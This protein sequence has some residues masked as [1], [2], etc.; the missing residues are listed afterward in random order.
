MGQDIHHIFERCRKRYPGVE[1]PLADYA[2]RLQ[3]VTREASGIHEEDLF[4]AIACARG[5]HVAWDRFA[6][7]CL[8]SLKHFALQA[9][10]NPDQAEDLA[11]EVVSSLM[12]DSRKLTGY[13]GR[14][15]L[16]AW[17]RVAVARAAIDRFRQGRKQVSLEEIA[18]DGRA[19]D[20]RIGLTVP[21]DAGQRLDE[22][23]GVI[24]S[25]L[26]AA[27]IRGLPARDRLLLGLYYVENVPLHRIA[28][29]FGVHESTASRW[30]EGLRQGLRRRVE[31]E[32]RVR[33]GLSP[34]EVDALWEIAAQDPGGL[35]I[36]EA[37]SSPGAVCASDAGP[38]GDPRG[39]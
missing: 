28:A 7:E 9:C 34:R 27:E 12:A 1:L 10:R 21:A 33:H 13:D 23:W 32:F 2:T 5:N 37:L 3:E 31:R 16:M 25:E 14:G 20:P 24:L 35:R 19:D 36:Q 29:Q 30:M 15:S 38:G 6:N 26:L 18:E 17:L 8:P 22:R 4:L 39:K 11:Q